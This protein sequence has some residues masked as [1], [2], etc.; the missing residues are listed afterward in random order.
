MAGLIRK[1]NYCTSMFL[2]LPIRTLEVCI[3]VFPE[4]SHVH[5]PDHFITTLLSQ[6][7]VL[8]TASESEQGEWNAQSKDEEGCDEPPGV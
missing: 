4:F 7:C 2:H 6:G 1:I 5:N 3:E 8:E